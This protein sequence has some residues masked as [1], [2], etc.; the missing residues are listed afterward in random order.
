MGRGKRLASRR[1]RGLSGQNRRKRR[2]KQSEE[3]RTRPVHA[4]VDAA[5]PVDVSVE[6]SASDDT[7]S[8]EEPTVYQ[9]LLDSLTVQPTLETTKDKTLSTSSEED[10]G[11]E[12]E[13]N[14]EKKSDGDSE[15]E[16]VAE[17]ETSRETDAGLPASDPFCQHFEV[18]FSDE[19]VEKLRT[20]GSGSTSQNSDP[21]LGLISSASPLEQQ[22]IDQ[23][24]TKSTI[25]TIR[26]RLVN[27]W[28]TVNNPE[29]KD[30]E[31]KHAFFTPLQ[32]SLFSHISNY[33]DLLYVQRDFENGEEIR[34]LY[35][36][37]ALNHVLKSRH[38]VMKN[39]SRLRQVLESGADAP[40][41]LDQGMTRPKVLILVPFRNSALRV[42]ETMTKLLMTEEKMTV[43]NKKRF[44]DEYGAVPEEEEEVERV[45]KKP[46]SF[47]LTFSGNT[48][49]CFR[50]GIQVQRKFV[51]LYAE[52][53][54]SDVIIASPL[55]LRTVIGA[56]GDK[57]RDYDFLS[58]I[59]LL[60]LDQADIFLMQNWDHVLLIFQ[61]LHL[62]PRN[63]HGCDISRLRTWHVNE[64]SRFYRQTVLFS[65][66]L[67]PEINSLYNKHFLNYGG[68]LKITAKEERGCISR[69][70]VTV[71]QVFK[72]IHCSS[73]VDIA[74]K[75]FDY[76]I[77]EVLPEFRDPHMS[78]TAIF[79]PSYFDFVRLRNYFKKEDIS[80]AQICEYTSNSNVSRARTYFYHG[81][82]HFLLYTERYHFYRRI[83]IRGMRHIIFY[84]LPH[85][86][87]FYVELINAMESGIDQGAKGVRMGSRK[88]NDGS[89]H[90]TCTAL[91]SQ[92]DAHR[93]ARIVGTS[94]SKRMLSAN[95]NIHM[96]V[97]GDKKIPH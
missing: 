29:T 17:D 27:H 64:W 53:Y 7:E 14:D 41:C 88:V 58:S 9:R 97:T 81:N 84:E 54:S 42:I 49:D 51:K 25:D 61:H 89:F 55:G 62:M 40:E 65:S 67:S 78:H 59:E 68:K 44:R 1:K 60:I 48:D 20:K 10:E 69:V 6:E 46:E 66:F 94:R 23:K 71:P 31:T 75:R 90:A 39:N 70:A 80:F 77:T 83:Q 37:H 19:D 35:C 26:T 21:M 93:L 79:V 12:V 87:E 30:K 72:R 5:A 4:E 43:G 13:L 16:E 57:S 3:P 8:D 56:P 73:I 45:V 36:L 86:H 63:A 15:P 28:K 85:Y 33:R 47:D 76:F 50:L 34:R 11:E 74:D 52:F 82:R 95:E 32:E 91:Y 96:I 92:F 18:N 24:S 2:A 22:I 38:R